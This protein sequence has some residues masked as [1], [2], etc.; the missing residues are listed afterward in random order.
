ME[1][2][3]MVQQPQMPPVMKIA[4]LNM[5]GDLI[6]AFGIIFVLL[7]ISQFLT[8]FLDIKGAGEALVG[9]AMVAI[10]FVILAISKKQ[11]A[12]VV[13]PPPPSQPPIPE[14]MDKMGESAYR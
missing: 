6:L 7:G 4:A 10:A 2:E 8:D 11:M 12:K 9:L 1:D 3:E 14:E 5:T 13:P